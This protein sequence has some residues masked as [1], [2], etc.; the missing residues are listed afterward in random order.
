MYLRSYKAQNILF[1]ECYGE[2]HEDRSVFYKVRSEYSLPEGAHF[3]SSEFHEKQKESIKESIVDIL[4]DSSY[5]DI[6]LKLNNERHNSFNYEVIAKYGVQVG[7]KSIE[8]VMNHKH[9]GDQLF[10]QTF[11]NALEMQS[12][13]NQK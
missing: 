9:I 13:F 10:D 8:D 5:T 1:I 6:N 12:R 3:Q 4:T 2:L 11:S 7:Y